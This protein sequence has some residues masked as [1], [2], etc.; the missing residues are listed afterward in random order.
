MSPTDPPYSNLDLVERVD[1]WPYFDRDP[2]AYK[3][4]MLSYYYFF[5]DGI[6]RP[7]GYMH[8]SFVE[9]MPWPDFWAVDHGKRTATLKTGT[10]F[11]T[12]TRLMKETMRAGIESP[13]VSVFPKWHNEL[14]AIYDANGEHVFSLDGTGLSGFG[15]INYGVHVIGYRHTSK[16]TEY[17]VPRRAKTKSTYPNMLDNTVGGSLSAGESPIECMVRE[18]EEE[19]SMKPEYTRANLKPCGTISWS[20]DRLD[21][22]SVGCQHQVQY[23]YEM[24]IGEDT[25][26]EI[27]DGEVGEINW[28]SL[29]QVRAALSN[30][31]FKLNCAMTW[32]AFL[33]RNGHITAE[34]EPKL[35][36]ICSRLHRKLDLFV[37]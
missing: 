28:K 15:V 10:D 25:V 36:E 3:Q 23:L 18:C 14:F 24:E 13:K 30:G 35:V 32:L 2:D 22:G 31:E 19:L 6:K 5:V 11:E 27:G 21:D 17:C 34:D 16:G 20:T 33:I 1:R 4:H 37:I 26:L 9:Q 7:L 29:D 12:R 8:H